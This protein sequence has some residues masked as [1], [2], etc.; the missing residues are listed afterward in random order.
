MYVKVPLICMDG[1]PPRLEGAAGFLV[2]GT[3]CTPSQLEAPNDVIHPG[4]LGS[5]RQRMPA[6]ALVEWTATP[7]AHAPTTYLPTTYLRGGWLGCTATFLWAETVAEA[8]VSAGS[9]FTL[10][11]SGSKACIVQFATTAWKAAPHTVEFTCHLRATPLSS[12]AFDVGYPSS[13]PAAILSP[14]THLQEEL[15]FRT[16]VALLQAPRSTALLEATL[17]TPG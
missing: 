8:L 4:G 5:E 12:P 17:P 7:M 16:T 3:E 15:A 13:H 2:S 6:N 10:C 14:A 1:E 11:V 9:E